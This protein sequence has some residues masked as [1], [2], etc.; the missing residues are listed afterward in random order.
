MGELE[1]IKLDT[2]ARTVFQTDGSVIKDAVVPPE[3]DWCDKGQ[4]YA[5]KAGGQYLDDMLWYCGAC[6]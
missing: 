6:K 5:T 1:I 2:G 3:I 4:H